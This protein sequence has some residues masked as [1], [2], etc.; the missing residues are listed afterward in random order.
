MKSYKIAITMAVVFT[1]TFLIGCA[2]VSKV[3]VPTST[4]N[5]LDGLYVTTDPKQMTGVP[6]DNAKLGLGETVVVCARGAMGTKWFELPAD[7]VVNWKADPEL[8]VT[9]TTGHIV[10]VKVINPISVSAYVTVTTTTKAGEKI[11]KE[12]TIMG[13]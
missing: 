6:R 8:E 12:F 10:T 5:E 1:I 7:V 11:E 9:P 4:K 3:K 2:K 13:K